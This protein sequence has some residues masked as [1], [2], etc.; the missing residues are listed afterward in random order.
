MFTAS[1]SLKEEC[2]THP[3][4]SALKMSVDLTLYLL[5]ER[6]SQLDEV[7]PAE[8]QGP[9]EFQQAPL[10]EGFA[11][12][13]DLSCWVK[14]NKPKPSDWSAWLDEG[15]DFGEKYPESQSSGCVVLIKSEQ[16]IF[17]ASFGTGRHAI[18]EEL[19]ECDFGLTVALNEVNPR[20][21]R[22]L[23]T[24][25]IDIKARQRD[26]KKLGGADVPEFAVDLDVEWLRAAEGRT[27][28]ADCNVVAGSD[29]LHLTG[30]RRSLQDLANAC[31]EFFKVFRQGV[32][33]AFEFAESVKPVPENDP[34]HARLEGDLQ[35]A[36]QLRYFEQLSLGIDP[37]ILR[38]ARR[39]LLAY[40]KKSWPIPDLDD[41]SLREG[42][43]SLSDYDP[44][45]DATR[46]R[47]KSFDADGEE[48][49][50]KP[51][52]SILQM[53]IDRDGNSYIR[54]EK[55]WFRC[56][57]NYVAR[58]N[59]RVA[60]LEDLTNNLTLPAW[61]RK[62]YP[63]E[64][65]Y[66]SHVAKI[67]NWLLQDKVPFHSSGGENLE[68]CDLLTP[69]NEFIHVK[70]GADSSK[71]SHLFSQASG[72]AVLL[73]RHQPFFDA[74]R[75]RHEQKWSGSKFEDCGRPRIVLAIARPLGSELFGKMLLSRI[76]VLE[77]ARRIQGQGFDFAI[78]RIDLE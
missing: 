16:R 10:R 25:T 14:K 15:F 40:D 32:P 33:E 58:V 68:P 52:I 62:T 1:Q 43:D 64:L 42:L 36:I 71:L 8:K 56:R 17:A 53:E 51:L 9:T 45:F 5:I 54:I 12:V 78:S 21:L 44:S 29:S 11:N 77:H 35:A 26:T 19:I 27:E 65:C 24:K 55:R 61:S 75:T 48:C 66:N 3:R 73:S 70:D 22:T 46:A 69:R 7:I 72:S 49:F 63:E 31:G 74:M 41:E 50:N 47:L 34:I 30:W 20:Q 37:A 57:D 67:K 2:I 23:I 13:A 38:V 28:R 39:S 18:P 59:G 76:N 6:I 60:E 4:Q